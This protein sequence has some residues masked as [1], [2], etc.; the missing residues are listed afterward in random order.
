MDRGHPLEFGYSPA[1]EGRR[2][3]RLVDTEGR[4][5]R[6]DLD[7]ARVRNEKRVDGSL[8]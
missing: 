3:Q 8:G 6:M 1:P 7:D 4:S 5:A 2:P